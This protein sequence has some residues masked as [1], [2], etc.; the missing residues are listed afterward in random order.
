[1]VVNGRRRAPTDNRLRETPGVARPSGAARESKHRRSRQ[2]NYGF[3]FF[4]RNFPETISS[5]LPA[6]FSKTSKL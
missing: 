3:F 6:A 1:M 5:I 2:L 4:S